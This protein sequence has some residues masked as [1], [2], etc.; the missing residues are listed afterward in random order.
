[1]EVARRVEKN[2]EKKNRISQEVVE[3]SFVLRYILRKCNEVIK[4]PF[5]FYIKALHASDL[6]EW[7]NLVL[8]LFSLF[9]TKNLSWACTVS[10]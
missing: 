1:M 3:E 4:H 8:D 6:K 9:S 5:L 2:F 7:T 10:T